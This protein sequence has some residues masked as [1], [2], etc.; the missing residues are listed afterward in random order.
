M[1]AST[2]SAQEKSGRPFIGVWFRCCGAYARIYRDR[3]GAVYEGRC[4]RCLRPVRV[5]VAP[6]GTDYRFFDAY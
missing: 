5:R 2:Q 6:G 4:P 3:A 1:T